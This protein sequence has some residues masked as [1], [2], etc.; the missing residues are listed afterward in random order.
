MQVG[1]QLSELRVALLG[2]RS[3]RVDVRL[4]PVNTT[5]QLR[6]ARWWSMYNH[7][8]LSGLLTA[9]WREAI[10]NDTPKEDGECDENSREWRWLHGIFFLFFWATV[11]HCAVRRRLP[12]ARLRV[13]AIWV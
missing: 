1:C 4:T 10:A 11:G 2:T 9:P 8:L 6:V 3:P 12:L 5:G 13:G 7:S